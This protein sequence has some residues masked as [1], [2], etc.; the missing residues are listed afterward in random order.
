MDIEESL[1]CWLI[2]SDNGNS[3]WLPAL[4]NANA[5]EHFLVFSFS[6]Y[7][8]MKSMYSTYD[9]YFYLRYFLLH[10]GRNDFCLFCSLLNPHL[11]EQ[12]LADNTHL[13]NIC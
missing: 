10:E 6:F 9:V 13:S 2:I 7:H 1:K 8:H 12:H 4:K 3:P 5:S 11:Q